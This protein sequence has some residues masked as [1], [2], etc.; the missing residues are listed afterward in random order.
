MTHATLL[1][2]NIPVLMERMA[3]WYFDKEI[4]VLQEEIVDKNHDA[5]V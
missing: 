4:L 1:T 2:G 5:E 3:P